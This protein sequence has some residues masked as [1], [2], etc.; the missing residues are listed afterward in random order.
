MIIAI[1]TS[2]VFS[3]RMLEAKRIL[4]SKGHKVFVSEFAEAYIGKNQEESEKLAIVHKNNNDAIR[5]HWEKIKKSD[6]ILVLNYDKRGIKNYVGGNTLMEMGF[7][8]VLDK[9]IF[10]LNP[11][12]EIPYYKSEIEAMRPVVINGDFTRIR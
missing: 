5:V 7:A 10:M 3:E 1:C 12:P 2:M 9:K 8:Y 6:A 11:V 4:E